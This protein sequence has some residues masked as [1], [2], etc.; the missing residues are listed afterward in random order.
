MGFEDPG[1][2]RDHG[3]SFFA[4]ANQLSDGGDD[5]AVIGDPDR[6][7]RL[8]E[9]CGQGF[10]IAGMGTGDGRRPA[11]DRLDHV[12]PSLVD[13]AGEAFADKDDGGSRIPRGEFPRGVEEQRFVGKP[14]TLRAEGAGDSMGCKRGAD[15]LPS[16]GVTGS[17]DQPKVGKFLPEEHVGP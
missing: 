5:V 1:G 11:A 16:L 2:G 17:D 7:T 3:R 9:V 10:E 8:A 14:A 12:L 4:A 15:L 6:G 13:G